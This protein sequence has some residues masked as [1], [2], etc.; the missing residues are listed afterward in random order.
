MFLGCLKTSFGKVAGREFP[1]S[2]EP[3]VKYKGKLGLMIAMSL[4]LYPSFS[5]LILRT[6]KLSVTNYY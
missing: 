3:D 6:I 1:G 2:K 5:V 4:I